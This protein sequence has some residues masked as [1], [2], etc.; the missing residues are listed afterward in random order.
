MNSEANQ[1]ELF[2]VGYPYPVA[3][4]YEFV[5]KEF[6]TRIGTNR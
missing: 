5:R 1:T 2:F 4:M 6:L 3:H